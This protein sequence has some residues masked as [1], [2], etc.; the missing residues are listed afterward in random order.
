ERIAVLKRQKRHEFAS[1]AT[2]APVGN[3]S[4]YNATSGTFT[5]SQSA[6]DA[7]ICRIKLVVSSAL[8]PTPA[9]QASELASADKSS[10]IAAKIRG[11][12]GTF[13]CLQIK[14]GVI[15]GVG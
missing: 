7:S 13:N 10:F 5:T 9:C 4:S 11:S 2:V 3:L 14:P 1:V 8:I 15:I 6:Q 12:S